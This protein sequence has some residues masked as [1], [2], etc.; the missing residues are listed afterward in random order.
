M[1]RFHVT[2]NA[3]NMPFNKDPYLIKHFVFAER[4]CCAKLSK[5]FSSKHFN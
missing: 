4:I 3:V 5:E 1:M 2:V